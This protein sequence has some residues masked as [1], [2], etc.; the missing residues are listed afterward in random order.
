MINRGVSSYETLSNETTLS[1]N[2]IPIVKTQTFKKSKVDK[3]LRTSYKSRQTR[4]ENNSFL[5]TANNSM[6]ERIRN[7]HDSCDELK[8]T[9]Q[10]AAKVV[11]QFILPMFEADS[12]KLTNGSRF[13]CF[14]I[15]LND[16]KTHRRNQSSEFRNMGTMSNTVYS[17]LKLSEQL[18]YEIQQVKN[19]LSNTQKKLK[20]TEQQREAISREYESLKSK[21][22]N[23]CTELQGINFDYTILTGEI[24]K[25]EFKQSLQSNQVIIYRNTYNDILK[26]NAQLSHEIQ[27]QRAVIDIRYIHIV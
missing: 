26:E 14:G 8:I 20:D 12:R 6:I 9:P 10:L 23:K 7:R 24:Q 18:S 15:K 4:T 16:V 11:K 19:E 1:S 17:E 3:L 25:L 27:S 2:L 5:M 21:H 13:D 22:T